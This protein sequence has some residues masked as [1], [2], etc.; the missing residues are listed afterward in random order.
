MS[1]EMLSAGAVVGGRFQIELLV[2]RGGMGMVYRARDLKASAGAPTVVALKLLRLDTRDAGN[3]ERFVREAKLLAALHHPGIVSHV[4]DGMLS[5]GQ[6]FLAMEWLEGEDLGHRLQRGAL[7]AQD[8]LLILERLADTLSL[9]H[10]RSII[11]RDLKPT[12]LFLPAGSLEQIKM[13]DFGIARVQNARRDMT[14]TGLIVGTPAY[15]APEQARGLREITPAADIY[16]LG[17]IVYE[18]LTGRPPFL[19]DQTG[20]MLVRVLFEEP[21]PIETLCPGLPIPFVDLVQRMMAKA[22]EQRIRD[23]SALAAALRELRKHPGLTARL[24]STPTPVSPPVEISW[25]SRTHQS[26]LSVVLA[27]PPLPADEPSAAENLRAE[28]VDRLLP[29]LR[30]LGS[31]AEPL[32]NGSLLVSVADVGNATEQ[33]SIAARAALAIKRAWPQAVVALA[34]GRG[35]CQAQEVVGEVVSQAARLSMQTWPSDGP[36]PADGGVLADPV[37]AHLLS[38]RFTQ[39]HHPSLSGAVLLGEAEPV[40]ACRPLFAQAPP[41]VG[42]EVELNFLQSQ[43]LS[44]IEDSKACAILV[45]AAPGLGKSRLRYEFRARCEQLCQNLSVLSAQGALRDCAVPYSLAYR[46]L[47]STLGGQ[48]IASST[49]LDS[50]RARAMLDS[51]RERLARWL[52]PNESEAVVAF[53]LQLFDPAFDPTDAS[54]RAAVIEARKDRR[55]MHDQ[56]RRAFVSW[57]SAECAHAPVLLNLDDLHWSDPLSIGLIDDA[58]RELR[59]APLFVLALAGPEIRK[60]FPKLWVGQPVQELPLKPLSR[61]ACERLIRHVLGADISPEQTA[62]MIELSAGNPFFLEELMQAFS[63]GQEDAA[64]KTIIAMLQARIGR[65]DAGPRRALSAASIY[66]PQAQRSALLA[67][68][69]ARPSDTSIDLDLSA[70]VQA[71]L[72]ELQPVRPLLSGSAAPAIDDRVYSFRSPLLRQSAYELLSVNALLAGH[73]LAARFLERSGSADPLRLAEHFQQGREPEKAGQYFLRAAVQRARESMPN[74][75]DALFDQANQQLAGLPDGPAKQRLLIDILLYRVRFGLRSS[76]QEENLA[77]LDEAQTLLL[78]IE[79]VGEHDISDELRRAWVEQLSGRICLLEGRIAESMLYCRRV[80]PVAEAMDDAPLLATASQFLSL[81]LIMQGRF[82][83][84]QLHLSRTRSLLSYLD[85][86]LQRI[87][88]QSVAALCQMVQGDC[89]AGLAAHDALITQLIDKGQHALAGLPEV[90]HVVALALSGDI[91]ATQRHAQQVLPQAEQS[92]S[93]L[94]LYP[95]YSLLAWSHASHGDSTQ[96]LACQAQ[97]QLHAQA[98]ASRMLFGDWLDAIHADTL[99]RCGQPEQ[100]LRSLERAL[101]RWRQEQQQLALA[102]GEQTLGLVH[103]CLGSA[104]ID[105][106]RAH[107]ERA[108]SLMKSQGQVLPA[109]RARIEWAQV[110]RRCGDR[111]QAAKLETEAEATLTAAA[112]QH[113]AGA[114][115]QAIQHLPWSGSAAAPP[116]IPLSASPTAP[117]RS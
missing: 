73:R 39:Q 78:G 102:L 81:A 95:L 69:G 80:L 85:H 27:T 43:L 100:A 29:E 74:G 88:T 25:L 40:P 105:Q 108:I 3:S 37:S 9:T 13:L 101:P 31:S 45:T 94:L 79:D 12:N 53:L 117:R 22:P 92:A 110:L 97:A 114:I 96:A 10:S 33:A 11:H 46:L 67:L 56:I 6:H 5:D 64:H 7:S 83:E 23:G 15:M 93:P 75:A 116:N 51:L 16:S 109:A 87:S 106:A 113:V 86:D 47:C 103:C 60:A 72:I 55:R 107:F 62:R 112:W 71:E 70:L 90:L 66:G 1:I 82:L 91:D 17:C 84:A 34:T 8:V 32:V 68:L 18:C 111:E 14:Q 49:S 99:L 76:R 36:L 21:P 24:P 28:L 44:C 104:R 57:L 59:G 26:L 89:L 2:S 77:C 19:D 58:L 54:V 63:S 65:L 61:R 98:S 4:A 41:T 52:P 20:T 115:A 42:R 38:G 48:D 50:S 35:S 30:M